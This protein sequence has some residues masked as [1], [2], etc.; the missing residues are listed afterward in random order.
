MIK[1]ISTIDQLPAVQQ[2]KEKFEQ[3]QDKDRRALY[4]LAVAVTV[5]MFYFLIWE[6]VGNWSSHKQSEYKRQLDAYE[7]M[8][9]NV[10]SARQAVKKQ[11]SGIGQKDLSS[12]VSSSSRQAGIVLSRVQ[13][14]RKGLGVW[15]EDA[16]YQKLLMWLIRLNNRY[17]IDL[18]QVKIEKGK[19]EGRVKAVL[20]LAR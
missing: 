8:Q 1:F 17:Q 19:E 14:D 5:A 4:L 9:S 3:L 16:A 2:L 7:W 6:P 20:H 13:P 12:I 10:E 11:K 15:I 18:Q